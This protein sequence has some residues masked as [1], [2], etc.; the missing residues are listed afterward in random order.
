MKLCGVV[1]KYNPCTRY[2]RGSP[3]SYFEKSKRCNKLPLTCQMPE[4][5]K[6][7]KDVL[8][9]K[10]KCFYPNRVRLL[11][12]LGVPMFLFHAHHRAIVGEAKIVRSTVQDKRH[13]YWFDE[14]LSYPYTVQLELLGTDLRL[15]KMARKGQ[16]LCVYIFKETIEEIRKLSKLPR[17]EREK[18][19]KDLKRLIEELEKRPFYKHKLVR[20]NWGFYV[21]NECE[22][23]KRRYKLNEEILAET[24]KYFS[25]AI[26]KKLSYG[27]SFDEVFYVSLYLAF[28][29]LRIP[30][31]LNDIARVSD[32]NPTKLGKL[33]RLFVRRFDLTV[34]P[35]DPKQ[36]IDFRS[37]TLAISKRTIRRAISLAQEARN[38]RSIMGRAPSA[39]AAVATFVACQ[40]EGEKIT[41]KQIAETFCVSAVTI[42]NICKKLE[43]SQTEKC[44]HA[45]SK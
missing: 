22:K 20:P 7:Y 13:F 5:D 27:R 36:L 10:R 18:L 11:E 1:V 35:L 41:Q 37:D 29:M 30:K 38:R 25:R 45:N 32:V 12:N 23:L 28:R 19:G 6:W 24:Q 17:K 15:P 43:S 42:R 31:L 8:D 3:C 40:K 2:A 9:G 14:F 44:M 4:Y 21:R 34:P 16:W 39:I 33:Y 26:Q